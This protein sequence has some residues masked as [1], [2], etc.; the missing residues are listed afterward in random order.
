MSKR[1]GAGGWAGTAWAW[2][3]CGCGLAGWTCG[4]AGGCARCAG[5]VCAI[6]ALEQSRS[7]ALAAVRI[8]LR[9]AL[10][11][12]AIDT[13]PSLVRAKISPTAHHTRA[14]R[15]QRYEILRRTWGRDP[16]RSLPSPDRSVA[17]LLEV[18]HIVVLG[19]PVYDG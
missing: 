3:S 5:V 11:V 15:E 2:G 12:E 4:F 16:S 19:L 7:T 8:G 17:L 9:N 14:S 18:I 13:R 6:G 1:A 10:T